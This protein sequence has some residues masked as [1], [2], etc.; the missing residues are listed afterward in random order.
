MILVVAAV[1]ARIEPVTDAFII[2]S[3]V[4]NVSNHR[5]PR[6]LQPELKR[7]LLRPGNLRSSGYDVP[8]AAR[9]CRLLPLP[10]PMEILAAK[11]A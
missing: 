10:L 4:G 11:S 9:V 3:S 1:V 8:V 6:L 2:A 7:R 5:C